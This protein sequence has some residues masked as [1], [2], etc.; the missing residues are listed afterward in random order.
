MMRLR[1]LAAL[2]AATLLLILSACGDDDEGPGQTATDTPSAAPTEIEPTESPTPV[3]NV[4][5]E[6]PDPGTPDVI[7]VDTPRAGDTLTNPFEVSGKIAAFEARFKIRVFDASGMVIVGQNAMSQEGQVLSLFS[8]EIEFQVAE[9]TPACVW[10]FE[11]SAMDG[12]P[13]HVVQIPVLLDTAPGVCQTNPDPATPEV[14][15]IDAPIPFSAVESPLQVSGRIAAFEAT[16]LIALFDE[17][18]GE[19]AM[20]TGMSAEGQAL[21]DFSEEIEFEVQED[22]LACLW[23]YEDSAAG[24]GPI[25]VAQIPVTLLSR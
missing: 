24:E 4:C 2:T 21:S 17:S 6:N 1:P 18:G 15:Q 5:K 9:P 7:V 20:V 19:I 10:V 13:I 16:F 3:P 14:L 25:H 22:T 11:A 12:S 23:V 8:E